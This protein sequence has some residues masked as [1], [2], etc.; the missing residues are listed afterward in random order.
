MYVICPI[1][2]KTVAK[3]DTTVQSLTYL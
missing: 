2:T 3:I 1:V